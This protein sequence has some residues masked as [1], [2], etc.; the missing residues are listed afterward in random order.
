MSNEKQNASIPP[1]FA[2]HCLNAA[3]C[4]GLW[5]LAFA[6]SLAVIIALSPEGLRQSKV[7][8]VVPLFLI[9]V[10]NVGAMLAASI[11]ASRKVIGRANG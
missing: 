4:S 11:R 2:W 6:L 8:G 7:F 10:L 5:Y 9:V 3:I 1:N